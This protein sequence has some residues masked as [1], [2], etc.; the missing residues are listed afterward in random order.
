MDAWD[1]NKDLCKVKQENVKQDLW[2]V[3]EKS[4]KL[5]KH[6]VL[7]DNISEASSNN[8]I[9]QDNYKQTLS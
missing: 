4:R 5:T 2:K 7:S 6:S 8:S 1:V 9:M 3:T